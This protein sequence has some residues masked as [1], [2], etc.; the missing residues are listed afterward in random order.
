LPHDILYY[1]VKIWVI[2]YPTVFISFQRGPKVLKG[3]DQDP[4]D[5]KRRLNFPSQD[6]LIPLYSF[7]SELGERE[8][9]GASVESD[10]RQD[11][12]MYLSPSEFSKDIRKE[13]SPRK[14]SIHNI[15]ETISF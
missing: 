7:P 4:P 6:I 10:P 14:S 11:Q 2:N 15:L 9:E 5:Y 13:K 12:D 1:E 3:I 8:S